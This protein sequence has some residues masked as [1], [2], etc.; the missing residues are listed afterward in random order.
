MAQAGEQQKRQ[1][2]SGE[3]GLRPI[4]SMTMTRVRPHAPVVYSQR[5]R[6]P[7]ASCAVRACLLCNVMVALVQS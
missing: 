7:P 1:V 3:A 6:C 5:L 2:S 4:R